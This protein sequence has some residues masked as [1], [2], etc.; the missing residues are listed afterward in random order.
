MASKLSDRLQALLNQ[1]SEQTTPVKVRLQADLSGRTL[2][3]VVRKIALR[4]TGAEYL[5]ISGTI[6]GHIPLNA[7]AQVSQ[8]PEVEWIDI[9]KEVPIDE[10]IDPR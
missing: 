3:N 4:L 5:S 7:V 1:H 10:L 9:E 2:K 6:H 8:L